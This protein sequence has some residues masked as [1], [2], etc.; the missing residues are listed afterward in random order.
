MWGG[1]LPSKG[2]GGITMEEVYLPHGIVGRQTDP[3]ENI[4]FPL[5]L[6]SVIISKVRSLKMSDVFTGRQWQRRFAGVEAR[7]MLQRFRLPRVLS[8]KM[9]DGKRHQIKI[10]F[11][12]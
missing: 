11:F 4:T 7:R 9:C 12:K 1:G 6:R 5:R 10:I 8:L 3:F 2:R